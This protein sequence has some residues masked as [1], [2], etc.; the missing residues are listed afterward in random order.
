MLCCKELVFNADFNGLHLRDPWKAL[1]EFLFGFGKTR[2]GI[3]IDDAM[4]DT[5]LTVPV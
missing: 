4:L 3:F 5:D 1:T 2:G